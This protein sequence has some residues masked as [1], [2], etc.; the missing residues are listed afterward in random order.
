MDGSSTAT[1]ISVFNPVGYPPK[2]TKKALAKRPESLDGKLIYLVDCRFDDSDKLLR[3]VGDWFEANMPG[4]KTK[5]VELSNMYQRDDPTLWE[6]MK[7]NADGAIF[8]VGH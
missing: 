3:Q 7:A 4:V 2:I 5:M 8:G 1:K 6:D